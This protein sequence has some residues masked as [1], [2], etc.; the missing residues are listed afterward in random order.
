LIA[1]IFYDLNL[2]ANEKS[3]DDDKF[4]DGDNPTT[5]IFFESC[6]LPHFVNDALFVVVT[7]SLARCFSLHIILLNK[8][9]DLIDFFKLLP[10][11]KGMEKQNER[12][13]RIH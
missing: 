12:S 4:N 6:T 1:P 10:T 2:N 3:S 9:K 8:K 5:T 13:E 7:K 11:C